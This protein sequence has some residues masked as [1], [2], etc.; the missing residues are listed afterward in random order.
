[1]QRLIDPVGVDAPPGGA[2]TGKRHRSSL[3]CGAPTA[4]NDAAFTLIGLPAAK[5]VVNQPLDRLIGA[6]ESWHP[7]V[8]RSHLILWRGEA[9]TEDSIT[10]ESLS[11]AALV[12]AT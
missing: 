12:F 11:P 4:A 8:G 3:R 10:S 5:P 1:M 2:S 9:E 6:E 7:P